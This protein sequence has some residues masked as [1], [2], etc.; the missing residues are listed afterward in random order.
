[1]EGEKRAIG[2]YGLVLKLPSLALLH[3][4]D[5]LPRICCEVPSQPAKENISKKMF[6]SAPLEEQIQ[7]QEVCAIINYYMDLSS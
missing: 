1:V 7:T 6:F 3:S 5:P 2:R 4:Q